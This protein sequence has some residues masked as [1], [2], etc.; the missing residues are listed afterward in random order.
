MSNRLTWLPMTV[1]TAI[2]MSVLVFLY[3]KTQSFGKSDY[4]EN[5]SLLR[6]LKQLDAQWE[7]DVLKSKIGMTGANGSSVSILVSG[8]RPDRT[9][10]SKK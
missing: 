7:L 9:V 8:C 6:H 5:V 4:F 1:L 10:G 3:A 2:L